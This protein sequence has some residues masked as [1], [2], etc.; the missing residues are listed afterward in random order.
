VRKLSTDL[1]DQLAALE[2]DRADSHWL[3][4]SC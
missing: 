2:D 4:R 3:P 1:L